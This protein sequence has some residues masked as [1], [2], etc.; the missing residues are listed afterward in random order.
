MGNPPWTG[1]EVFI[2]RSTPISKFSKNLY[3]CDFSFGRS[4][5]LIF[6]TQINLIRNAYSSGTLNSKMPVVAGAL[7]FYRTLNFSNFLEEKFEFCGTLQKNPTRNVYWS[8]TP[9]G[10]T[11][12]KRISK[13][14]KNHKILRIFEKSENWWR[15][16]NFWRIWNIGA[17]KKTMFFDSTHSA[18]L[19]EKIG[20]NQKHV[21]KLLYNNVASRPWFSR[22]LPKM[23]FLLKT[24]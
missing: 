3:Y 21:V 16:T 13:S 12:V 20:V 11:V 7:E 24:L 6:K 9:K 10:K 17:A 14:S 22:R 5:R 15:F 19:F 1:G 4:G 2:G 23:H 18:L 8:G